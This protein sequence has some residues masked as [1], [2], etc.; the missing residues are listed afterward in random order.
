MYE[1]LVEINSRGR[2]NY[3][4]NYLS[5]VSRSNYSD[6]FISFYTI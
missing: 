4:H 3:T 5:D 1:I 2:V 6:L